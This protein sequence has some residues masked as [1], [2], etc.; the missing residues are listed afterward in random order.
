MVNIL[1]LPDWEVLDMKETDHD[2]LIVARY[3]G[4]PEECKHCLG[5]A[6]HLY[7]HGLMEHRYMDLPM[8]GKRVGLKVQRQR[9]RCRRCSRT[10]LQYLPDMDERRSATNRLMAYIGR[11]SMRR[12]FTSIADE[13]GI[14]ERSVRRVFHEHVD[15]Y[16]QEVRFTTPKWLGIDEVHLVRQPRCILTNIEDRSVVDLLPKR[17]RQDVEKWLAN[18]HDRH[19]VEL[20]TMD[21]WAPYRDAVRLMLPQAVIVIDKFHVIKMAV[22]AMDQVRKETRSSLTQRQSRRLKRDRF[23]L[24]RRWH[25]LSP[26]DQFILSTWEGAFPC[27]GLAYRAKE[28][29]CSIW[30]SQDTAEAQDRYT[31]WRDS[32]PSELEAPFQPLTT[33]VGNWSQEIWAY[34]DH[35]VTNA[36]TEA[37]N[38]LVKLMNRNGRGYSF[39]AIRAKALYSTLRVANRPNYRLFRERAITYD[40]QAMVTTHIEIEPV[41]GPSFSTLEDLFS[42]GSHE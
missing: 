5:P 41:S 33:A 23:I 1:N 35:P 19:K 22:Q 20:V 17:S 34:F 36:Y 39:E 28:A 18:L 11:E 38:G 15:R 27:L 16:R 4:E 7:R 32:L 25:E 8:H 3:T 13:T 31:V 14:D 6:D 37:L 30:D 29:F 26:Q 42:E 40:L 24:F 9:Y 2:Y 21:M 10:F 12:T